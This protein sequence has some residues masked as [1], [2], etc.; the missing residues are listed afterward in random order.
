MSAPHSVRQ[1][2]ETQL[3]LEAERVLADLSFQRSPVQSKLL[4]YLVDAT[5][6]GGPSPSQY[7]IAVDA[8]G[9][10]PDF[11]L[12]N[13]SYPR[14]QISRL[15]NNLDAYYARNLPGDRVRLTVE[16]G[17]YRLGLAEAI[18]PQPIASV[19]TEPPQSSAPVVI[20][21]AELSQGVV[22]TSDRIIERHSFKRRIMAHRG[23][24][25]VMLLAIFVLGGL[26]I[27]TNSK[28]A[29]GSFGDQ[30]VTK[31]RVALS[32]DLTG[33]P[34]N[35]KTSLDTV[36]AAIRQAEIQ[37]A[38]SLVS[39][40]YGT[41][42]PDQPDYSVELSF[43]RTPSSGL[44]AFISLRGAAGKLLFS[45]TVPFD[46]EEPGAFAKDIEAALVYITSPTGAIAQAEF[47]EI[48]DEPS[49]A[50]A[51][52]IMI[53]NL[54]SDGLRSASLVDR[55]IDDFPDS[56]YAPF[57]RARR[58]FT[59]YQANVVANEPIER[60]GRAWEDLTK[61][62]EQDRFNAFANFTAAKVE[63]AN[64]NCRTAMVHIERSFE[65]SSSYP[66]MLAALE[67]EATSCEVYAPDAALSKKGLRSLI[68]R[69]PAP[70]PLLHLYLLL[71]SLS[72][73]DRQSAETLVNRA[74]V[75]APPG[76]ESKTIELLETA[77]ADR[78]FAISNADE[79]RGA[80]RLFVWGDVAVDRVMD[81]L[82]GMS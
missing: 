36:E 23:A 72:S 3:R 58:A 54:R 35:E 31:P 68:N 63:L 26:L 82:T 77:M 14:V 74:A 45:D 13:D 70:D 20:D 43:G 40:T 75:D 11:D 73:Q 30:A 38:Y 12:A 34:R 15:R 25:A 21:S 64:D 52:F 62:L 53:E 67:A 17:Q 19:T 9:K 22:A 4:R 28:T 39:G 81:S 5:L 65:R 7:E 27:W 49:S 80:V 79:I 24:M 50:Y 60:S 6:R 48:A 41:S 78:E 2:F 71:A 33:L 47:E 18:A 42:K 16:T 61:A 57:F 29:V 51:C 59:L 32:A 8:L 56:E 66:A 46:K 55:C 37:L 10:D 1:K 69:N 76:L 44:D